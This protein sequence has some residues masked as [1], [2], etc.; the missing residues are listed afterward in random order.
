MRRLFLNL[1]RGEMSLAKAFWVAHVT[2]WVAGVIFFQ[3]LSTS[4]GQA[5]GAAVGMPLGLVFV[6]YNVLALVGVA[7]SARGRVGRPVLVIAAVF[8][9]ALLLVLSTWVPLYFYGRP[10]FII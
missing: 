6:I 2:V 4:M 3:I 10:I 1:W 5:L 9:S 7:R 8:T